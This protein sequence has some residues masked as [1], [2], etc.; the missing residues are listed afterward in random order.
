MGKTEQ[1]IYPGHLSG[2]TEEDYQERSNKLLFRKRNQV[3]K[4]NIVNPDGWEAMLRRNEI[5]LDP[6]VEA[7]NDDSTS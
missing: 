2:E 5:P 3:F 1:V 6:I 4:A 7:I